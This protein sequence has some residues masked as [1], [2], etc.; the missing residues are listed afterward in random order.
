MRLIS[1]LLSVSIL[2]F[3]ASCGQPSVK[4]EISVKNT[5]DFDRQEVVAIKL[6]DVGV[7]EHTHWVAKSGNE[8]LL[9]QLVDTDADSVAD[10]L[11]FLASLK[12]GETKTFEIETT[13]NKTDVK[14]EVST[15]SR[16]VPERTDDYAWEND[17]V[18][19][20]TYGP[21]AQRMAEA[22]EK[23]GTLSSGLDCWLKRV[24]YPVIDKWYKKNA[25][26]GSYHKD[27]G[28]GYDPYHVGIS[29]GCGGIGVWKND[30]LY[31]SRNF[32]SWKKIADGP[33]RNIFE[34]TYAPWQADGI[35]INETK[36]ITIDLGNQLY[37]VEDMINASGSLPNV[38]IGI[39][40]HDAK[41][42]THAD[43]VKGTF[44]YWEPIDD[45]EIG[46]GVVVDP[47]QIIG[48][49]DY[50]TRKKDL[51][52]LYI[53]TKPENKVT[54]YTGFAWKKAGYI[55]SESEWNDYLGRFAQRIATPLV[56][57]IQ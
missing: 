45:S 21:E 36:R 53:M 17:L 55:Q 32:V 41:G 49:S 14:S 27:D 52:Q 33:V 54:Y 4:K 47:I 8:Q 39:T 2:L 56:V 11:I 18:A 35:S 9:S 26:G 1:S 23:A 19:F 37:K 7:K 5:L 40:L 43:T 44:S 29:R 38:A 6:A 24:N 22:G 42:R 34:L 10:E 15:Y 25:E 57:T 16:F 12:A 31:V 28:E 3:L 20:R 50:R 46:T 48:H 51:S 13:A 30:S